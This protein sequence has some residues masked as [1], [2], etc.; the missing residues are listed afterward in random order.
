MNNEHTSNRIHY[1]IWSVV[2]ET[3]SLKFLV[4]MGR[5]YDQ[6]HEFSLKKAVSD[7]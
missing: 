2:Y 1:S 5:K 3:S 6:I 7:Q 4:V